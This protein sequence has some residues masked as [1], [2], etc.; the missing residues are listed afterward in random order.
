MQNLIW[1]VKHKGF[2]GNETILYD[3]GMVDVW[4]IFVN[5]HWLPNTKNETDS[6]W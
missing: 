4:R 3:T 2:L 1:L 6:S 5:T